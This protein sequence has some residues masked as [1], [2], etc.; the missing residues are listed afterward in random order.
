MAPNQKE[1]VNPSAKARKMLA[2]H[3]HLVTTK[4]VGNKNR[5]RFTPSTLD[6]AHALVRRDGGDPS[7]DDMGDFD[8]NWDKNE[9]SFISALSHFKKYRNDGELFPDGVV[10]R[11]G[12]A[13]AN[14]KA[15]ADKKQDDAQA[16][17]ADAAGERPNKTT[18]PKGQG[19]A[20]LASG[21][22]ALSLAS[23]SAAAPQAKLAPARRPPPIA[24][25]NNLS[26]R[27]AI[28]PQTEDT[29]P[30]ASG[31]QADAPVPR[32]F[33]EFLRNKARARR[34]QKRLSQAQVPQSM[35]HVP[36]HEERML[37]WRD[38]VE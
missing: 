11:R 28:R 12:N 4:P 13:G 37:A 10:L 17:T 5:L 20:A 3:K 26:P 34:Q 33:L 14:A 18:E 19:P 30:G 24:T 16:N 32:A 7:R 21:L 25:S 31:G 9:R 8:P 15:Q 27:A 2:Y 1:Q 29:A 36:S 38:G 22:G 6:L 23:P 35:P